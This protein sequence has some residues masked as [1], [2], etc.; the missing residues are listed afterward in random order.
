MWSGMVSSGVLWQKA[1]RGRLEGYGCAMTFRT[2]PL[3]LVLA[4]RQFALAS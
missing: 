1:V 4:K 3:M 2:G